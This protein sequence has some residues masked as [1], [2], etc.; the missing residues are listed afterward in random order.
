MIALTTPLRGCG[1]GL[2]SRQN[3]APT[4]SVAKYNGR[5][6]A[7]LP[8]EVFD[9]IISNLDLQDV[10]NCRCVS[11]RWK[12]VIDD[13]QIVPRAFYRGCH[14]QKYSPDPYTVERYDS[15]IKGWLNKF[16]DE[17]KKAIIPLDQQLKNKLFPQILC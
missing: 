14:L 13:Y 9:K 11:Q 17:G 6:I 15:S 16:G 3:D 2:S 7:T 5:G 10:F 4:S 1:L 8:N 12:G